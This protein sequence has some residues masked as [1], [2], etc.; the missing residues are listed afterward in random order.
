[1]L[2]VIYQKNPP[3]IRSIEVVEDFTTT[4]IDPN[5][6]G[7]IVGEPEVIRPS[8]ELAGLDVDFYDSEVNRLFSLGE[9]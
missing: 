4:S 5:D 2:R 1:M 7:I 3:L 9:I 6:T 8:V